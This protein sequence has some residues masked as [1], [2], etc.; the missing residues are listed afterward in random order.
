M[1]IEFIVKKSRYELE[2]K[3]PAIMTHDTEHLTMRARAVLGLLEKWGMV[4]GVDG[5]E[6]SAGRAK[7]DLMP[8]KETVDRAVEM[9]ETAFE[10]L[11]EKD[12]IAHAPEWAELQGMAETE[13]EDAEYA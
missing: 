6:D 9:V 8:V 7:L 12:W 1:T 2:G 13:P 11:E 10:A 3:S 5:G 4:Q